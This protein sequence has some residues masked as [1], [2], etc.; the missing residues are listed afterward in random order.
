MKKLAKFGVAVVRWRDG[1]KGWE[2]WE[3]TLAFRAESSMEHTDA[4]WDIAKT[5]AAKKWKQTPKSGWDLVE[6]W[7]EPPQR[8]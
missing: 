8:W 5:A 1:K 2:S 3:E 7:M 4:V 6:L